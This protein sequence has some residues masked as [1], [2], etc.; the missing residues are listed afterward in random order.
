MRLY[1][2]IIGLKTLQIVRFSFQFR[3]EVMNSEFHRKKTLISSKVFKREDSLT[4]W[5]SNFSSN[6]KQMTDKNKYA[7]WANKKTQSFVHPFA[8]GTQI[9]KIRGSRKR[10]SVYVNEDI[11]KNFIER[12]KSKL[13]EIQNFGIYSN[14]NIIFLIFCLFQFIKI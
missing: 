6:M 7:T 2:F 1:T 14:G 13:E 3:K 5:N 12:N 10:H 4:R 11:K 8:M 9:S